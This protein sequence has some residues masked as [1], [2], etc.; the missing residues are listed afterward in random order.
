MEIC[1]KQV[2]PLITVANGTKSAHRVA[3][4]LESGEIA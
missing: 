2:P 4:F 1:R 3:C